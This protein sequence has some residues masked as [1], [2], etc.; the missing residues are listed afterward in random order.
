MATVPLL[1]KCLGDVAVLRS[2]YYQP[3]KPEHAALRQALEGA[4]AGRYPLLMLFPG[5]TARDVHEVAAELCLGERS[6]GGGSVIGCCAGGQP[7]QEG[8]QQRPRPG[9]QPAGELQDIQQDVQQVQQQ[10]QQ[11]QARQAASSAGPAAALAAGAAG[12]AGTERDPL[13]A[14]V[15]ID[16]TWKQAKE[17]FK[18]RQALLL[19]IRFDSAW[20]YS[21]QGKAPIVHSSPANCCPCCMAW[22]GHAHKRHCWRK[23]PASLPVAVAVAVQPEP[24]LRHLHLCPCCAGAA[25]ACAAARWPWHSRAAAALGCRTAGSAWGPARGRQLCARNGGSGS[26]GDGAGGSSSRGDGTGG[27]GSRGSCGAARGGCWRSREAAAVAH[28]AN[29]G[30]PDHL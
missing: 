14:L 12:G 28:G 19:L 5:A 30:L 18:V 11:Q 7:Q 20:F 1:Q 4:A 24:S 29:G 6:M 2:R 22:L 17:M 9:K 25:A 21:L 27:S 10:A 13:Y 3:S 23:P 16:G 8:T 15:V 26:E